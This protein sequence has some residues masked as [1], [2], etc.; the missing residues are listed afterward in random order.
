MK[1][2]KIFAL[3]ISIAF[4]ILIFYKID[5]SELIDTF[6][7][8]DCKN[9]LWIIIF[10][11]LSLYIRGVRWKALLLNDSKY[12]SLSLAEI[13]TVGSMLNVFLPA[14]AGDVYRAYYL[15]TVKEER[16]MKVLGS[17]ILERIFDGICVFLILLFAVM[18][19]C[20]QAWIFHLA[21]G[22][23]TLF[24]GSLLIFYLIFKFDKID[25]I[26]AQISKLFKPFPEKI[27]SPLLTFTDKVRNYMNSF[28]QGFQV[29]DSLKY[30]MIAVGT[31][32]LVWGLEAYVAFLI[33]DSFDLGLRFAAAFFVISLTSF[34]T[35]IPSTSVFLG[36]YQYA[37]ILA[38]GI[39]SIEKSTALA[40]SAIHQAIFMLIL[41][42]LGGYYLFKCN[43]SLKDIEKDTEEN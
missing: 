42:I 24:I 34:S 31:S 7:N 14:R 43:I 40:V 20:R 19:Y 38:L 3:V 10:Y 23:G 15:G 13:F 25:W 18:M 2:R 4:L 32:F 37:Y 21:F 11:V 30:T 29:L 33:V 41:T 27:S 28:M 1:K 6:K 26:F 39:F 8:F 35:M 36:P 16:K 5:L 9:L 22:I 12:S 17:I